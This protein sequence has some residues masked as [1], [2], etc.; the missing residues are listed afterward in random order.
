MT[1]M[2]AQALILAMMLTAPPAAD[3]DLA[4]Q[5]R[6]T[7]RQLR[8]DELKERDAA[9]KKL[10]ELGPAAL[11]NLPAAND[12]M[13]EE[14][15]QRLA[16]I[17]LRLEQT[18][19]EAAAGGTHVTLKVDKQPLSEVLKTLEKLSGN[20]IVSRV[21]EMAPAGGGAPAEPT[22]TLDVKDVPFWQV[23]DQV[24]DQVGLTVDITATD[25]GKPL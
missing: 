12:Q 8:A 11:D 22:V 18:R 24:L 14:M 3:A 16:R 13:P 23:L 25:E 5:V 7:V 4:E 21:A 2:L 19:A 17:R 10:L 6:D 20:R 9:E 1:R 15:R